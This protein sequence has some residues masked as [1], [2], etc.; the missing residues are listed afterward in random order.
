MDL[1]D[2]LSPEQIATL[3]CMTRRMVPSDDGPGAAEANVMGH[4]RWRL[5][6]PAYGPP[7]KRLAS[8]LDLLASQCRKKHGKAF[9]ECTAREQDE[10]L[11]DLKKVRHVV[12][13]QFLADVLSWTLAGYLCDP[14]YG[15]NRGEVGWEYIGFR[16]ERRPGSSHFERGRDG[17]AG[18]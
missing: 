9:P 13:W 11:A 4:I 5:E 6:H 14:K 3:D 15:G 10:V 18:D 16:P 12:V 7:R 17:D 1:E 8:G 2:F